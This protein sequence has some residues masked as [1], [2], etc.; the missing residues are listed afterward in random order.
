M[1]D[2]PT[3]TLDTSDR[4]RRPAICD[5]RPV[6]GRVGPSY[7]QPHP[8]IVLPAIFVGWIIMDTLVANV[9]SYGFIDYVRVGVP[10]TMLVGVIT[11]ILAPIV[12]PY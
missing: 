8:M 2:L 9:A 12:Y 6:A 11:V 5:L 7:R 10:L 3:Q 4:F 1:L